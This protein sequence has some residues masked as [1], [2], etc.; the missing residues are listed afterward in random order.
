M[1]HEFELVEDSGAVGTMFTTEDGVVVMDM[2]N[3]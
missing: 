1:E 3:G 2:S